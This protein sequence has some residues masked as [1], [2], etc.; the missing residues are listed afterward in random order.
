MGGADGPESLRLASLLAIAISFCMHRWRGKYFVSKSANLQ[1]REITAYSPQPAHLDRRHGQGQEFSSNLEHFC[2]SSFREHDNG[3]RLDTP[4]YWKYFICC[5]SGSFGRVYI[6][7]SPYS[8]SVSSVRS[9][10]A[11]SFVRLLTQTSSS[12]FVKLRFFWV[13]SWRVL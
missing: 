8:T 10:I 5:S 3:I 12:C 7:I 6:S 9:D 2:G 4:W 13:L 11:A 1:T